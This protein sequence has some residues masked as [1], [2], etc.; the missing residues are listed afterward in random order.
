MI[1]NFCQLLTF[2]PPYIYNGTIPS[3]LPPVYIP[4]YLRNVFTLHQAVPKEY[5]LQ[6]YFIAV[7]YSYFSKWLLTFDPGYQ[8]YTLKLLLPPFNPCCPCSHGI[9][10]QSVCAWGEQ[11]HTLT[12]DTYAHARE[13]VAEKNDHLKMWVLKWATKKHCHLPLILDCY[14]F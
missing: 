5:D 11:T 12:S 9:T 2:P 1:L 6:S 3:N 4:K 10:Q 14:F 7:L 13:Y 8:A